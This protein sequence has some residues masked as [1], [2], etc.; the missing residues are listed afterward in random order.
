MT[1]PSGP[2]RSS[3]T[4]IIDKNVHVPPGTR[5]GFDREE[6]EARF[7]VSEGGIVAIPKNF[8]F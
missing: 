3:G 5:I 7:T 4:T 8:V 2:A 1:S 6:D